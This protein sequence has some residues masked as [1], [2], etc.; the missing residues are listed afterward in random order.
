MKEER[1][2][3]QTHFMIEL[4]LCQNQTQTVPER[5]N[6]R[7]I[8]VTLT[9]ARSRINYQLA[10]L[11]SVLEKTK[12][13][14]QVGFILG[15]QECLRKVKLQVQRQKDYGYNFSLP[16]KFFSIRKKTPLL[17]HAQKPPVSTINQQPLQEAPRLQTPA[18]MH[19]HMSVFLGL[20]R[21]GENVCHF[22][23]ESPSQPSSTRAFI[24]LLLLP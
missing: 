15:M 18:T 12:R 14:D 8:S 20:D 17:Q 16:E 6:Y 5:K 1:D 23:K 10:R 3:C 24:A 7:L 21:R 9:V 19:K 13:N 2:S 22:R 11:N 4:H